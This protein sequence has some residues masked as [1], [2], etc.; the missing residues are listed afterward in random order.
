[1]SRRLCRDVQVSLL[2]GGR[3]EVVMASHPAK[4]E[5]SARIM[6]GAVVFL[7]K[8]PQPLAIRAG[9][10]CAKKPCVRSEELRN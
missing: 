5:V 3:K 2:E 9:R 10:S 4:C 6:H 8:T 1:M 7:S